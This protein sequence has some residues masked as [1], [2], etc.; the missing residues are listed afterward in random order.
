MNVFSNFFHILNKLS[1]P[2]SPVTIGCSYDGECRDHQ[3]CVNNY[4]ANPC[5]TDKP[6]G[7]LAV[8]TPEN[9]RATCE[10]SPG[11]SGDPY[12]ECRPVKKGEC[13]HDHECPDALACYDHRCR[14]PCTQDPAGRPCGEYAECRA[15]SHRAV[16]MCPSGWAGNPH[17]KC[18]QHDC[19]V[20]E[21]CARD[22]A[23][24][25]NECINP[26]DD[27]TCGI[28]AQ[29]EVDYHRPRCVCPPGTKM[30]GSSFPLNICLLVSTV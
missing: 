21:D 26:C 20:D 13:D 14:N 22:R 25:N 1:L 8:C 12:R 27:S 24:V 17:D 18:F 9:H 10:C 5:T 4:C 30:I 29:C 28:R 2:A 7:R 15:S 6:C 11:T 23:C 16:C 19:L 3:A